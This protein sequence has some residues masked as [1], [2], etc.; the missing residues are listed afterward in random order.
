MRF[1]W[2]IMSISENTEPEDKNYNELE[3][4]NSSKKKNVGNRI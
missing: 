2:L 1:L 3:D 4:Y